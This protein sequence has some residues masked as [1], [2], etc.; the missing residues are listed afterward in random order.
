MNSCLFLLCPTDFLEPII[1]TKYKGERYFYAPLGNILTLDLST[2]ETIKDLLNKKNI[3]KIYF[4]LADDNRFFFDSLEEQNLSEIRGLKKLNKVI[5]NQKKQSK[6]FW[7][8]SDTKHLIISYYLNHKI[9][10]L[11]LKLSSTSDHSLMIRGKIYTKS[12]NTFVDIYPNLVCL[13]KF[14]LN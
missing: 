13:K 2:V 3:R 9:K 12:K 8:A 11:E 1:G 5:K 10:E 4:V 6:L 7:L 14:N